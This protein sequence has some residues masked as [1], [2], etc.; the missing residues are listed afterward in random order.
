MEIIKKT[1]KYTIFKKKSGRFGVW[2]KSNRRWANGE[3]KIKV[4][5]QE[6]LVTAAK[7]KEKTE[8]AKES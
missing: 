6:G 4:L 5:V 8:E 7:A 3:E 1:D 2:H